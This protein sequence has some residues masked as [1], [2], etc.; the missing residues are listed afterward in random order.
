M[1]HN[2]A[3]SG[4]GPGGLAARADIYSTILADSGFRSVADIIRA[5]PQ[6]I[7]SD[8]CSV[9]DPWQVR[10]EAVGLDGAKA[11]DGSLACAPRFL[12]KMTCYQ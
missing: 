4:P 7:A 6:F 8:A 9:I 11:R 1:R 5:F 2:V 12:L 10:V 3:Q